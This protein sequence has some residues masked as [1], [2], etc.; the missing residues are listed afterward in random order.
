VSII[1]HSGSVNVEGMAVVLDHM[2][3]Y[4]HMRPYFERDLMTIP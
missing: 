2:R 4:I 3:P 1:D